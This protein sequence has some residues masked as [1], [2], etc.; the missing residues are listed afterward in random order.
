[1]REQVPLTSDCVVDDLITP[2][3]VE[4]AIRSI[5]SLGSERHSERGENLATRFDSEVN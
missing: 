1:V 5:Y 2:S 3:D 4:L